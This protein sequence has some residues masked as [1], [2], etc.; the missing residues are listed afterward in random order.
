[1]AFQ[2][3]KEGEAEVNFEV[4]IDLSHFKAFPISSS[5]IFQIADCLL[6]SYFLRTVFF[7][8]DRSNVV[9]VY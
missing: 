5:V 1:M 2:E 4:N 9:Y 8:L 6:F 7:I 3:K